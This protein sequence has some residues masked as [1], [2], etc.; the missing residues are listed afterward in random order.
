MYPAPGAVNEAVKSRLVG[1]SKGTPLSPPNEWIA[2]YRGLPSAAVAAAF[3]VGGSEFHEFVQPIDVFH[4]DFLDV[5]SRR[6][7]AK[8]RQALFASLVGLTELAVR[9]GRLDLLPELAGLEVLGRMPFAPK[10]FV[11]CMA[12]S[13]TRQDYRCVKTV[14][15]LNVSAIARKGPE[16][17]NSQPESPA[18]LA[19]FELAYSKEIDA[20]NRRAKQF[21]DLGCVAMAAEVLKSV[22]TFT[23][24]LAGT[25]QGFNWVTFNAASV[26]LAKWHGF[27]LVAPPILSSFPSD[28]NFRVAVD[29]PKMKWD[30]T[31]EATDREAMWNY[32]PRV[33]P[34]H[35]LEPLPPVVAE[36][37]TACEA[38]K[39]F[40]GRPLFD[41]Y[42]VMVPGV[43]YPPERNGTYS[44]RTATGELVSYKDAYE[45]KTNLDKSLL[46][47][48][49]ISAMVLG[50]RDNKCYFLCVWE[51]LQSTN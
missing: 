50:E 19:R 1:N 24:Q 28:R 11:R 45:A 48:G 4:P 21:A 18:P 6:L 7:L 36:I 3:G 9:E 42:A 38:Y 22:E 39:P 17:W 47:G 8:G 14:Q 44:F 2:S 27:S 46:A 30:F 33:Y 26:I 23:T 20:A 10:Q 37:V 34:L 51:A 29:V 15:T 35:V 43:D 13:Q 5:L 49:A 12:D 41:Y 31:V 25:Y 16:L 32:S 40:G